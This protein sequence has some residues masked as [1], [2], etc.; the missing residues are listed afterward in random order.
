[1][2]SVVAQ[3]QEEDP[4]G[5]LWRTPTTV[6]QDVQILKR[7]TAYSLLK[8]GAYWWHEINDGMYR[9]AQHIRT[10]KRFQALGRGLVPLQLIEPIDL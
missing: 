6:W 2:T 7:D 9:R 3:A 4:V 1:R 8:G 10:A 5:S